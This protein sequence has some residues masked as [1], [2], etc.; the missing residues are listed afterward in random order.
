MTSD[1]TQERLEELRFAPN[2]PGSGIVTTW[3]AKPRG[4]PMTATEARVYASIPAEGIALGFLSRPLAYAPAVRRYSLV[5]RKAL[6]AL[7]AR[8]MLRVEREHGPERE[9]IMLNQ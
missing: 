8:G 6:L 3:S 1:V 5:E 2:H 7:L 9:T 4:T